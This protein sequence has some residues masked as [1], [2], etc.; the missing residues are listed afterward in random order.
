MK[1]NQFEMVKRTKQEIVDELDRLIGKIP[2]LHG[3]RAFDAEHV[4]WRQAVVALLEE[5]FGQE[6]HHFLSFTDLGWRRRG[7]FVVHAFDPDEEAERIHHQAYLHQLDTAK[8]LLLAARDELGR[9]ELAEVYRGKNTG[10]EASTILKVIALAERK[11]RK[12][13]RAVP[14]TEIDV[15]DAFENLLV[16]ADIAYLREA[17]RIAYSSKT[18]APDFS[19]QKSD[20][21][22]EIKLCSRKEREKE[23]IAE[24]NDDIL[25]Y[26]TKY[27]N[28]LFVVYDTGFIRDVE[29]FTS[30]F[31]DQEGVMVKVIKH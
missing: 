25:A 23:I 3:G 12:V 16:G 20:M 9:K 7:Q 19:I 10:P 31:E 8:G 14:N 15:Q 26:K 6:S 28:V 29:R 2:E 24:I 27:G 4:R 17:D 11:L 21:V 13:M 18:Y 1:A 30:H 5:V 22:I